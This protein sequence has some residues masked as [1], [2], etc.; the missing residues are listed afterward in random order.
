MENY[1]TGHDDFRDAYATIEFLR[2]MDKTFDLLNSRH[3]L[4]KG[5]KAP[6]YLSSLDD[7]ETQINDLQGYLES[8]YMHNKNGELVKVLTAQIGTGFIG[9]HQGAESILGLAK[10]LLTHPSHQIKCLLAYR[11]SQDHI[12]SF[13]SAIRGHLGKNTKPTCNQ[14]KAAYRMLVAHAE[15]KIDGNC[16]IF[17]TKGKEEIDLSTLKSKKFKN[18]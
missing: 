15:V 11:I 13:F 10:M 4:E 18:R 17:D 1:L 8:L 14:F 7:V 16:Q 2:L 5:S 3:P 12:E 9:F 6:L